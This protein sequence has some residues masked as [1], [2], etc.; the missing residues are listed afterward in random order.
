MK[1]NK[2][3]DPNKYG[4]SGYSTGS[5]ARSNFLINV[6]RAKNVVLFG[7]DNSFSMHTNNRE[8]NILALGEGLTGELDDTAIVAEAKYPVNI[9][10][11]RMKPCLRLHYNV[12]N[13]FLYANDM[14]IHQFNSKMHLI[15][16]KN[17]LNKKV[18][19]IL[20]NYETIDVSDIENI[21]KY[22]MKKH[23]IVE[24]SESLGKLLLF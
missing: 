19:N 5:D 4:Y 11:S 8:K 9:T 7:V 24:M 23:S 3:A 17:R 21:H 14:K 10:K 12:G 6:E 20:I 22:F 16:G 13:S 15:T 2:N 18:R 1:L